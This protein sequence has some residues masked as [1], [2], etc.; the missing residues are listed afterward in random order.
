MAASP[1]LSVISRNFIL[2]AFFFPINPF[3]TENL[4]VPHR[5][6]HLT[7]HTKISTRWNLP[8]KWSAASMPS[9]ASW[10][11]GRLM[12]DNLRRRCIET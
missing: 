5:K 1:P 3:L 11:G 9:I 8:A 2:T 4:F 12:N 6:P 7:S 10:R